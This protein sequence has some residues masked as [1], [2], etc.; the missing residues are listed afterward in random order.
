MKT[1][2][3]LLPTYNAA[4]YIK[5]AID[6]LL[7]QTFEDFDIYIYDDCSTDNTKEVVSQF[8]D[9]RIHYLKNP[10]NYGIAKTLNIGL[11]FLENSYDYI[12]RMD[13]DDWC[14]PERFEKQLR[15]LKLH[16]E[17]VLCGTQGYWVRD[18]LKQ[19]KKFW[20]APENHNFIKINLLFS[21]S[22]G[23]SSIMFQAKF[24]RN[25]AVR[26]NEKIKTCE[27]WDLW[28]RIVRIGKVA[29]LPDFLM[30]YRIL[31]QSNHRSETHQE[32]HF[33]ERSVIISNYW[34]YFDLM[35]SPEE[36]FD[37]YFKENKVSTKEFFEN[38]N[39]LIVIFNVLITH[40]VYCKKEDKKKLIYKLLRFITGYRIRKQQPK[41]VLKQ[42]LLMLKTI[43]FSNSLEVLKQLM[44]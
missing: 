3:V 33:N 5:T 35:L 16:P 28:T 24:L 20:K 30:K 36:V 15:Y 13:A 21:G 10:E 4:A 1:L 29:N 43:R 44:K 8:K 23:H 7:G 12:A 19:P 32:L 2:A 37:Y 25:N 9:S 26:Y 42:W 27:D 22:F 31:A 38:L 11:E 14:Y 6:S 34:K 40:A 39:R 41:F 17:I 18:L